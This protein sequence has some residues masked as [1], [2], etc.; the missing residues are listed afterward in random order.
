[1]TASDI[2]S[3]GSLGLSVEISRRIR[4][5]SGFELCDAANEMPTRNEEAPRDAA[6]GG[7]TRSHERATVAIAARLA[8][9]AGEAHRGSVCTHVSKLRAT[10]NPIVR[11]KIGASRAYRK[12]SFV[13]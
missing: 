13:R 8:M 2:C 12:E 4:P 6:G 1:V 7:A 5:S 9:R 10:W 3:R 11:N